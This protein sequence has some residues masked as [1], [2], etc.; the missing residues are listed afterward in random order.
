MSIL[1]AQLCAAVVG[2]AVLH[3]VSLR[4]I[5]AWHRHRGEWQARSRTAALQARRAAAIRDF[6]EREALDRQRRFPRG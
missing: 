3:A 4:M 5:Q 2:F 6:H 1:I